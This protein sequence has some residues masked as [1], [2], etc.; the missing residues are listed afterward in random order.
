MKLRKRWWKE[1]SGGVGIKPKENRWNHRSYLLH[2][3]NEI[4]CNFKELTQDLTAPRKCNHCASCKFSQKEQ[5][6]RCFC[7]AVLPTLQN[8]LQSS[9]QSLKCYTIW[10]VRQSC[11]LSRVKYNSCHRFTRVKERFQGKKIMA[12][13]TIDL[14][15]ILQSCF[16][17]F[18]KRKES[19][20]QSLH[21]LLCRVI[22]WD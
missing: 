14:L 15:S 1:Q 9:S 22:R 19:C 20:A 2:T 5:R 8:S 6:F 17:N 7:F 13:E 4:C 3:L 11:S 18:Q 10:K 12:C 21:K 16:F